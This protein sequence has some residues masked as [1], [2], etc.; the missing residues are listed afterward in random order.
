MYKSVFQEEYYFT[1]IDDAV[2]VLAKKYRTNGCTAEWVRTIYQYYLCSPV[3]ENLN[4]F[5]NCYLSC[6]QLIRNTGLP[7]GYDCSC[8]V[9]YLYTQCK[10]VIGYGIKKGI[11]IIPEGL[12]FGLLRC[13]GECGRLKG[14]GN[15]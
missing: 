13:T 14:S 1:P 12:D 9:Y 3:D 8:Y 4:K 6:W 11:H 7:Y 10:H 2:I 5:L 15:C